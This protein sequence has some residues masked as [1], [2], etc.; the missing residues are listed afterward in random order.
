[1]SKLHSHTNIVQAHKEQG[2]KLQAAKNKIA[3]VIKRL[4][5]LLHSVQYRIP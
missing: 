4:A 5:I 2:S 3:V 1:M